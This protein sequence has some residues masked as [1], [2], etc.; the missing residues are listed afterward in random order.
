[1]NYGT[2]VPSPDDPDT[3]RVAVTA[4]MGNRRRG[5]ARGRETGLDDGFLKGKLGRTVAGASGRCMTAAADT[6]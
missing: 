4:G 6:V 2:D 1:M 5:A 3:R